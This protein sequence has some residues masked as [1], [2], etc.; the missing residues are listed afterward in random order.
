MAAIS[1]DYARGS[2]AT[3]AKFSRCRALL[4]HAVCSSDMLDIRWTI[5]KLN[6]A[7]LLQSAES[8]IIYIIFNF[9]E[10]TERRSTLLVE[11]RTQ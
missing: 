8:P 2:H 11:P 5:G 9:E 7:I 1:R 10:G 4:R 6:K 3:F